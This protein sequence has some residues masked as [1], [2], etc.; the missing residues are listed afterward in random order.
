MTL[1]HST[2]AAEVRLMNLSAPLAS[3]TPFHGLRAK[4]QRRAAYT[5]A[6]QTAVRWRYDQI[7]RELEWYSTTLSRAFDMR[8]LLLDGGRVVPPAI[9]EASNAF[10]LYSSRSAASTITEY[11]ILTPARIATVPPT[12]RQ[13]LIQH[14][15]VIDHV[16]PVLLPR[17]SVE[18]RRWRAAIRRGWQRGIVL[19]GR[20]L[21]TN[22]ARLTRDMVGMIRFKRLANQGVVS[23][24]VLAANTPRIE[25]QGRTI[26][27][28]RR[29]FRI[30]QQASWKPED[31]WRPKG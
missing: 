1:A 9:G 8:P 22:I 29:E 6:V 16:N 20:L 15:P 30:T 31:Q 26:E 21:Q 28:G 10:R 19:A 2:P 12:W 11:R 23:V 5:L 14:Y 27:I 17:N 4:A 3:Q 24:P 7:D 13:Y 25:V 18:R